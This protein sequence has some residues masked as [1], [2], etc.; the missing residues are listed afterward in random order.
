MLHSSAMA[1]ANNPWVLALSEGEVTV[2]V[3]QVEGSSIKAFKAVTVI[4]LPLADVLQ[5]LLN[6]D[7]CTTWIHQC[8]ESKLLLNDAGRLVL[9]QIS[10]FPFP[11]RKRK[12]I[13]ETKVSGSQQTGSYHIQY[14]LLQS[15]CKG[16][17]NDNCNRY[18][19]I[20]AVP[21][22]SMKG[23]FELTSVAGIGTR[24]LW[25]QHAEPGGMLPGWMVNQLL[26]DIPARSLH[27][28][29]QLHNE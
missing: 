16:T 9:F 6:V 15:Y 4:N 27:N 28:L 5:A 11:A 19:S 18:Q 20:N 10:D 25:R 26:V 22:D 24:V 13:L 8:S 21:M 7:S 1:T 2:H 3:R 23:E 17:N 29:R 12:M 14:N